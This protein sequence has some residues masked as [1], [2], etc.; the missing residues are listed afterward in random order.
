MLTARLASA[1]TDVVSE[2]AAPREKRLSMRT[3]IRVVL[4][5]SAV[6]TLIFLFSFM[7]SEEG[8]HQLQGSR[9][10]VADLQSEIDRLRAENA[11]LASEIANARASNFAIERVARED[12]GMSRPGEIVY[13]LPRE[14]SAK[15]KQ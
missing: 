14:R 1:D 15:P 12:L 10:R 13:V 2:P 3:T 5:L 6:L 11:K 9:K 8:I 4:L 7:F